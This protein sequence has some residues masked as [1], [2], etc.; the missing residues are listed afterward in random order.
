MSENIFNFSAGPA[1]IPK[2]VIKKITSKIIDFDNGMSI[3]EISHRSKKFKEYAQRSQSSLRRLLNIDDNYEVLFLQGGATHQFT[4]IPQ[5]FSNNGIADYLITG[6]WSKKAAAY[7]QYHTR[8]NVVSDSSDTN[9]TNISDKSTWNIFPDSDYFFY[10]ANETVHGVEIHEDIDINAPLICDMSSTLCTRPINISNF[11]LLFAGA[12]KNL[13]IAGLTIV[14]ARKEFIKN[15][16]TQLSPIMRYEDHSNDNSM[17][18]TSPVFAWYVAGLVFEWIEE[19]GGL[20]KMANSNKLKSKLLYDYI[21]QSD[22][23]NNPIKPKYRSWI[24]IPFTLSIKNL[25][26]EFLT[27]AEKSGLYNLKGHR[28]VGGM[29]AS[30]YNAMPIEGVERLISFMKDFENRQ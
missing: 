4:M 28:T 6:G 29:R 27:L 14:L 23:Y 10:C 22:L 8:V 11:D 7:A 17:L 25:D 21:D 15:Q 12:Q 18:N 1:A 5:N 16:G 24:N 30:V 13:G 20:K 3:L 19:Q 9:F 26:D 2:S